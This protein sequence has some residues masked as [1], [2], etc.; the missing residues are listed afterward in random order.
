M[1]IYWRR[2]RAALIAFRDPDVVWLGMAARIPACPPDTAKAIRIGNT[3]FA[4]TA[5]QVNV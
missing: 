1:R 4:I 5:V 2:L 3:I